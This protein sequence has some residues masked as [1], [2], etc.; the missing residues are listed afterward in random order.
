[1]K[2]LFSLSLISILFVAPS[3]CLAHHPLGGMPVETFTDGLLS[4]VGH[5]LLGFDHLFFVALV[6][7]AALYTGKKYALP[8]GYIVAMLGGCYLM[9]LGIG[10]PFKE[11]IIGISLLS[12]GTI[13]FSGRALG[14]VPALFVFSGFGFFHGSAFGDFIANSEVA[15]GGQVIIGYF[16]GLGL[17]Q[18]IIA[19][20]AGWVL[21]NLLLAKYS[22]AIEAR[23]AGALVAGAGLFIT[24][25]NAEGLVFNLLNL[26]S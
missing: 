22:Q 4:G 15:I 25:E 19:I 14:F 6:G 26:T 7:V 13:V 9:T 5:P 11:A 10:L 21:S 12:L 23:I 3:I 17:I 16:I 24:M 20:T 2:Q 1:M 8:A 18:Y